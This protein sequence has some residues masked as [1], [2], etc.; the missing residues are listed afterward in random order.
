MFRLIQ[1]LSEELIQRAM[2]DGQFDDLEGRGR[3]LPDEDDSH[4]PPDLRM[5]YKILKNAGCLPPELESRKD[6]QTAIELLSTMT[7]ERERFRQIR[8][9]NFLVTKLNMGRRRPI[10]LEEQEFYYDKVVQR[11]SLAG[12]PKDGEES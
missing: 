3:P 6:I 1:Q 7:D 2:R 11:V 4:V 10:A 8:K 5:P 12:Q 9:L